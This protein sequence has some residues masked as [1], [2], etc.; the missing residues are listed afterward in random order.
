MVEFAIFLVLTRQITT[1]PQKQ[2][3]NRRSLG[4]DYK[5]LL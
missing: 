2:N 4:H 5:K 3:A 1:V